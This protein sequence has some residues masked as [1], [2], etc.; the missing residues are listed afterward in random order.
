MEWVDGWKDEH[1]KWI[2]ERTEWSMDY[3]NSFT[4]LYLHSQ[5]EEKSSFIGKNKMRY[6][7]TASH[8][9]NF[10]W[11]PDQDLWELLHVLMTW[12]CTD[13]H[14]SWTSS[15]GLQV[16][17][18]MIVILILFYFFQVIKQFVGRKK[19]EY[20]Q[21]VARFFGKHQML[22]WHTFDLRFWFLHVH[23]SFL[24]QNAVLL[25]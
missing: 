12:T 4:Q 11:I 3:L 20:F 25:F 5:K 17:K 22:W 1:N 9:C 2:N 13:L 21:G 18:Y 6:A 23:F 7:K 19:A 24:Q 14:G 10:R 15:A 8:I 16:L